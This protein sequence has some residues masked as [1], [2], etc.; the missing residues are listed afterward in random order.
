MVGALVRYEWLPLG[1]PGKRKWLSE[2]PFV[3]AGGSGLEG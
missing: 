3:L 1:V 2:Y